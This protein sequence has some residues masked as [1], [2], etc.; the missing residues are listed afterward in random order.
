MRLYMENVMPRL[1]VC[2]IAASSS[3]K[4]PLLQP[5][6]CQGRNYNL[7]MVG[8]TLVENPTIGKPLQI[9]LGVL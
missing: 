8:A 2:P 6:G 3:S 9:Y 5:L 7:S 1:L 4:L